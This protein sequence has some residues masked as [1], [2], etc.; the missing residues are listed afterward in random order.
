MHRNVANLVVHTDI[1]CLSVIQY[2]VDVLKVK[3]IMVVGHYGCGGV[4][5]ALHKARVGMVDLW[6]HNV[7]EVHV[8]HQ[9]TVDTLQEGERHDRLCELTP[10]NR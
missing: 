6:L 8:K 4:Q 2:A 3:H 9:A 5:A 10:S 7:Q 1:N